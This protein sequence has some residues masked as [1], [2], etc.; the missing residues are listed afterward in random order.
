V[1]ALILVVLIILF[2]PLVLRWTFFAL[3]ALFVRLWGFMRKIS[4]SEIL[5]PEH[6]ALLDRGEI[7]VSARCNAHGIPRGNGRSGFLSLQGS[8][9][10]FTY[11]RWFKSRRW[12][13]ETDRILQTAL[14]HRFLVDVLE[15]VYSGKGEKNRVA[16][17]AFPKDR[18]PLATRLLA[19][20]QG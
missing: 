18:A 13:L 5:P 20:V 10:N 8:V 17:F 2:V 1:I 4:E 9:L 19:L 6:R 14:K 15:V 3:R 12:T 7:A 11:D 16:R